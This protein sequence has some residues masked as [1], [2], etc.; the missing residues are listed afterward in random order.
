MI[1]DYFR[2]QTISYF[3]N[4]IVEIYNVYMLEHSYFS[5]ICSICYVYWV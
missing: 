2:L 3:N 1:L 5:R 4:I